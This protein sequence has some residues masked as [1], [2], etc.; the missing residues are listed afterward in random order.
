L[1]EQSFGIEP[2]WPSIFIDEPSEVFASM[3]GATIVRIGAPTGLARTPDGGGLAIEYIPG[4][5]TAS[6][7]LL[8]AFN[9]CGMWEVDET[10]T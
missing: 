10:T 9:E 6:R 5:E 7:T 1:V 8:I 2:T 4:G 3:A